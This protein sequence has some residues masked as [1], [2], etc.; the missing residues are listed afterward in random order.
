MCVVE[1]YKQSRVTQN[2]WKVHLDV[3]YKASVLIQTKFGIEIDVFTTYAFVNDAAA[4]AI[5]NGGLSILI[6][7]HQ[8]GGKQKLEQLNQ[9]WS[10]QR[11]EEWTPTDNFDLVMM[12]TEEITI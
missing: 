2:W 4:I 3:A 12:E 8:S 6:Q 5:T 9:N 7:H 10:Q 11:H 1:S